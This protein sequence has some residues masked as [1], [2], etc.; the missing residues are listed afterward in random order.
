M[1]EQPGAPDQEIDDLT[2][3]RD[4]VAALHDTEAESGDEE[5]VDDTYDIDAREAK[6]LGVAL[7]DVGAEQPRLN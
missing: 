3:D 2:P 5:G 7:D 4:G 1:S 6:E